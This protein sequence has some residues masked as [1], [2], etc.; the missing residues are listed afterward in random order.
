MRKSAIPAPDG[1]VPA[2]YGYIMGTCHVAVPALNGFS[3]VP[4]IKASNFVESPWQGDILNTGNKNTRRPAVVTHHLCL[5]RYCLYDLVCHLPAMVAVSTEF[6]ENKPVAHEKYWMCPGSLICCRIFSRPQRFRTRKKEIAPLIAMYCN[7]MAL[8]ISSALN[9]KNMR[10]SAL[11]SNYPYSGP[12]F[13][14]SNDF[15][16]FTGQN[17]QDWGNKFN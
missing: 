5:I 8:I 2:S 3:K 9:R 16:G 7:P 11:K 12:A 10:E 17:N 6:R 13:Q 4:D 15:L 14:T 1:K